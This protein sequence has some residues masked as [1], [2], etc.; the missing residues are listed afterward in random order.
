[1]RETIADLIRLS[2]TRRAS[3]GRSW[4]HCASFV[5]A[6]QLESTVVASLL[7]FRAFIDGAE[8]WNTPPIQRHGKRIR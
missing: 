3:R 6:I 8:F 1:M 2:L 5:T 4:L 7:R